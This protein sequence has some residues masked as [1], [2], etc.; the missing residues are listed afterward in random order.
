ME[1][2][3]ANLYIDAVDALNQRIVDC[4]EKGYLGGIKYYEK[5]MYEAYKSVCQIRG[6][7]EAKILASKR[8]MI[9]RKTIKIA[10]KLRL[11]SEKTYLKRRCF[12]FYYYIKWKVERIG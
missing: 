2:V 7:R 8:S 5:Q 3:N 12:L 6:R 1:E 11:L 9:Y 10:D 4:M